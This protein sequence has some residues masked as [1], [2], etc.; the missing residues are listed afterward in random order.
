MSASMKGFILAVGLG[1]LLVAGGAWAPVP[2]TRV[3]RSAAQTLSALERW[4]DDDPGPPFAIS[5][6]ANRAG[7]QSTH[8][9]SGLVRNDGDQTFAAIGVVA[10]FYSEDGFQYGPIDTRCPCTLLAPGESCPFIVQ[11][12]MRKP[13]AFVLHPEGRPTGHESAPLKVSELRLIADGLNSVRIT[14]VATNDLPFKIKNPVLTG[15]LVDRA[16]QIVSLGYRYVIAQGI[17]PGS[18]L[19]FDVRVSDAPHTDYRVYA[20]AE[21]DW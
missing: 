17:E 21:R 14:G 11:A 1:L 8:L 15:V 3:S 20:Q 9:V 5:V 19:R 4:P 13:I 12:A 16:G 6:S 18:S 7:P 2:L 10:T